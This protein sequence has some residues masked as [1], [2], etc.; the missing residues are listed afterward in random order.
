MEEAA[1]VFDMESKVWVK[2]E[3]YFKRIKRRAKRTIL[4]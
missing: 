3:D 4:K 1:E 2:S